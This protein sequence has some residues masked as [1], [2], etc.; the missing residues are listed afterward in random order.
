MARFKQEGPADGNKD[1]QGQLGRWWVD[2]KGRLLPYDLIA[3][4]RGDARISYQHYGMV[5]LHMGRHSALLRWDVQHVDPRSIRG[6]ATILTRRSSQTDITLEFFWGG[7]RREP[8]YKLAEAFARMTELASF[9][10]V[11]PFTGAA[12]ML[13]PIDDALHNEGPLIG[14]AFKRWDQARGDLAMSEFASVLPF[15]L[16]FRVDR[17]E[18]AL[19]FGEVGIASA[20]VNVWGT[21]WAKGAP[22]RACHRSQ[23][24]FEYDDRV[25]AAYYDVLRTGEPRLEHVRALIRREHSDPAWLSYR[26]LVL[27]ARDRMGVPTVVSLCDL[28]ND[29]ALPFMAA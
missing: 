19:H 11:D 28:S 4:G 24:D 29:L 15:S 14:A 21:D 20:A 16:T 3:R 23:P 2:D 6:A 9:R 27:R 8:G 22:G 5:A 18:T 17:E 13:R 25:C 1:G 26:R 7:W 12:M 10:Q